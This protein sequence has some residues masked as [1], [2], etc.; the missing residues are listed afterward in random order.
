VRYH[1]VTVTSSLF[2]AAVSCRP[3]TAGARVRAGSIYVGFIVDK[4]ALRQ[5]FIR[6][7]RSSTVNI[8]PPWLSI[9]IYHLGVEQ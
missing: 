8:I 4:V 9:L 1:P 5:V 3:F 6:V 7:L 2:Y